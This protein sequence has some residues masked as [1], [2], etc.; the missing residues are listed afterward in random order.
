ME[1]SGA[2]LLKPPSTAGEK[3]G[4]QREG[5][6][7]DPGGSGVAE[8]CSTWNEPTRE[9]EDPGLL[10]DGPRRKPTGSG[11]QDLRLNLATTV[12]PRPTP[13]KPSS[14]HQA[15]HRGSPCISSSRRLPFHRKA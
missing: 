9:R 7:R 8:S 4:A 14:S 12:W 11:A 3:P 2:F 13:I 5:V 6:G 1:P 15:F 10:V